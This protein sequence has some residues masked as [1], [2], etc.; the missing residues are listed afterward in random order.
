[1]SVYAYLFYM[2]CPNPLLNPFFDVPDTDK[3]EM[4]LREVKA[5]FSPD[6][7]LIEAALGFCHT[8]YQTP[9]YRAYNGIK[10]M[11]DNLA[12]YMGNTAITHGRDGNITALVNAAAKFELIRASYKG[13]FKDLMEEQKS[14][15]R[16][17]ANMAYDQ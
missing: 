16:G 1:M 2:T 9:T 10:I 12:D 8:L 3:E 5:D 11:L 7:V 15:V 4:I 17:G 14:S 13:A 6:E